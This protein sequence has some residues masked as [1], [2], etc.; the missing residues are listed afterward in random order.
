VRTETPE[1]RAKSLAEIQVGR[2]GTPA[3][4]AA[5]AVYIASDAGAF[6]NASYLDLNGGT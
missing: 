5:A 2:F 1:R 3:D 6:F 4:I